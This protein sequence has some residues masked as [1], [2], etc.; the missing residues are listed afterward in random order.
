[1]WTLR[2]KFWNLFSIVKFR[3]NKPR[4]IPPPPQT[5]RTLVPIS[6]GERYPSIPIQ[7]I[8]VTGHVPPDESMRARLL[9]C[10]VQA[11]LYRR[12]PPTQPGLPPI[13]PDPFAALSQA[14]SRVNRGAFGHLCSPRSTPIP[15]ISATLPWRDRTAAIS[16]GLPAAA[17]SGLH[18]L[19]GYEHHA[20]LRMLGNRVQ[21]EFDESDQRLHPVTI[22]CEL[23]VC[24][25]TDDN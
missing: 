10:K 4:T 5:E 16:S 15:S 11:W 21:F 14:Y 18:H 12:F 7:T 24:K 19:E 17:M 13:D 25:P 22:D 1:M 8:P 6:L 2:K 3:A 23:G 9:F 20:G